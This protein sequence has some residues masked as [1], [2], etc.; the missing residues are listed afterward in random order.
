MKKLTFALILIITLL[1]TLNG[2]FI[3]SGENNP[4]EDL[5][6]P[7]K[8]L[9]GP[10]KNIYIYDSQDAF[11]KVFSPE[12]KFLRKLGGK[13]EGPGQFKRSDAA[14]FGFTPDGKSIYFTEY[15]QGHK[16]I[17]FLDITGRLKKILKYN[18]G[19]FYGIARSSVFNK[20]SIF[21]QKDR[22]GKIIKQKDIYY[23][24][25]ISEIIISNSKG[26]LTSTVLSRESPQTISFLRMGGDT[27]IPFTPEFLWVVTKE[28]DV[29]FTDGTTDKLKVYN[30]EGKLK[31]RITVP[32]G[33]PNL[34]TK[35]DLDNWRK[36]RKDAYSRKNRSW[37][38][39]FG[40]V[41]EK[42]TKSIF[43]YKPSVFG[44][45]LTPAGNILLQCRTEK[46]DH[47]DYLLTDENGKFLVKFTSPFTKIKI[48]KNY[49]IVRLLTED[50]ETKIFIINRQSSEEKDL[51][52]VKDINM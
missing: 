46:K 4:E 30:R 14:D 11:I 16:W 28:G 33:K 29:I 8:I 15:F 5:I 50:E 26:N 10:D 20:N 36:N 31:K 45:S 38:K 13:G 18:F 48:T 27:G 25:Y 19:G 44:M 52:K 41:I 24:N 32:T 12:G 17:T 49:I 40:S 9:E 35:E 6:Y 3:I 43:K 23:V 39:D 42:Y 2:D 1:T 34:V 21:L 22:P 47:F 7:R 37:Y 51:N